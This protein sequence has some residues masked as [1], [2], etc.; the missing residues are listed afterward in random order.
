MT[1]GGADSTG[2]G[3]EVQFAEG[4]KEEYRDYGDGLDTKI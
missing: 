4:S 1:G 3:V 2:G